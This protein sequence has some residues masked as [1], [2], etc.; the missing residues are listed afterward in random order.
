[1]NRCGR[2]ASLS[3]TIHLILHESNEGRH[4]NGCAFELDG[5][6]LVTQGLSRTGG[7]DGNHIAAG[8]N[9]FDQLAL[10]RPKGAVPKGPTQHVMQV[11]S[12]LVSQ[13]T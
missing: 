12:G 8:K 11:G 6:K 9:L 1:V 13:S 7:H 4:H 2:N 5:G 10:G 3:E